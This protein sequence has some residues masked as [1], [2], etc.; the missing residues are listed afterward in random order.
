M[1]LDRDRD[2]DFM[3]EALEQARKSF[4]E[5]GIPVGAVLVRDGRV[6]AR[7]HNQ[8]FQKGQR[9]LHGEMDCLWSYGLGPLQGATLYTTLNPCHMCAGTILQFRIERVVI[10]QRRVDDP[11]EMPFLGNDSFLADHGVEVV[12]LDHPECERLFEEFLSSPG[13]RRKWRADIGLD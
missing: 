8:R 1:Q 4:E 10:G 2:L 6:V 7:G 3:R 11:P 5:G 13:G 12:V 9:I